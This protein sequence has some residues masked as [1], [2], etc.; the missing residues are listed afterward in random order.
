VGQIINPI[1]HQGQING[2]VMQGI[3]FALLEELRR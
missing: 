3:G 1:G 2:G